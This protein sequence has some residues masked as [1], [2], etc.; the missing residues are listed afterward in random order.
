MFL[1][2]F[3]GDVTVSNTINELKWII[4]FDDGSLFFFTTMIKFGDIFRIFVK[5]I[6]D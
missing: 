1:P 6:Y 5:E 4:N 3:D 2:Y